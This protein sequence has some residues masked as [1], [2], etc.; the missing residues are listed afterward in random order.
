MSSI[1]R[2]TVDDVEAYVALRKAMLQESPQAFL[3]SPE[4]DIGCDPAQMREKLELGDENAVYG[5]Y[6]PELVG[7]VGIFR[8]PGR[9][10][11]AHRANIWGMYV[12]PAARGQGLGRAL[13]EAAVAHAR[14]RMAGVT[15]VDLC[16]VTAQEA[17][18]RLYERCGFQAWGIEPG[19]MIV[20][21]R[22]YDEAHM[23]LPLD[24]V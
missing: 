23:R 2:L 12:D 8:M 6:R 7:V 9:E 10:K 16:V 22:A 15:Q 11:I 4:T 13:V 18:H 3:A 17:A 20:E 5:A 1:R 24:R 21:G 19:A 14:E